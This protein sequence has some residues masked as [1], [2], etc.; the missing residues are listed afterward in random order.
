MRSE[1]E[2]PPL[3]GS[4]GGAGDGGGGGASGF[5]HTTLARAAATYARR[6]WLVLPCRPGSKEPLSA[7]VP[8]GLANAT[9][10]LATAISW[11]RRWPQ[12]NIAV[13]LGASHLAA[14]DIDNPA[15]AEAVLAACPGLPVITW[16]QKTPSGGLHVVVSYEEGE[17]PRTRHLHD[18]RGHRLG[19]LRSAGAYILVWPSQT[20]AGAYRLLSPHAPWEPGAVKSFLMADDAEAYLLGLLR[21]AG[22][23]LRETG[24]RPPAFAT[25]RPLQEGDGRN[26]ALYLTGRRLL[27]EGVPPQVVEETLRALNRNPDVIAQPLP[28][29][30]LDTVIGH[31]LTQPMAGNGHAPVSAL[32]GTLPVITLVPGAYD[33]AQVVDRAWEALLASGRP[34]RL[35]RQGDALVEVEGGGAKVI[36]VARLR[37]LLARAASWQRP[38]P[39]GFLPV[40]PPE[41]VAQAMLERPHPDLP[42]LRGVVRVPII[43]EEGI[44]ATPGYHATTGLYYLPGPGLEE[45]PP[46]PD[47]PTA[48]DVVEAK[49]L[50]LEELLGDF[51]FD[52]PASRAGAV[53]MLLTPFLHQLIAGPAPLFLLDKPA[54]GSGATLLA[55]AI[56][57]VATGEAPTY[58]PPRESEEEWRKAITSILMRGAGMV[59]IDNAR[60]LS[61]T[62]LS[63]AITATAWADRLLGRNSIITVPN[64]ATWAVSG[65]NPAL[66]LELA[67]RCV[68]VRLEPPSERPWTRTGFRYPNLLGWVKEHRAHLVWAALVLARHWLALGRPSPSCPRPGMFEAWAEVVGGVL[69]SAGIEG[70]LANVG[71]VYEEAEASPFLERARG[72]VA[73]WWQRFGEEAVTVAQLVEAAQE[74]ELEPAAQEKREKDRQARRLGTMLHRLRGRVFA[75][76]ATTV[77]VTKA[78]VDAHRKQGLWRLVPLGTPR[79]VREVAGS[80]KADAGHPPPVADGLSEFP[81]VPAT[82]RKGGGVS[83]QALRQAFEEEGGGD[84]L[85]EEEA[86]EA[87]AGAPLI[88]EESAPPPPEGPPHPPRPCPSCRDPDGWKGKGYRLCQ[89]PGVRVL[90]R[91]ITNPDH[92]LL[93]RPEEAVAVAQRLWQEADP[94]VL[95][96]AIERRGVCWAWRRELEP[97]LA[98]K[99]FMGF[100]PQVV[101]PLRA[102]IW[103]ATQ[104]RLEGG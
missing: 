29:R 51:P 33:L 73:M 52:C 87:G 86:A 39:H 59:L 49:R 101:L 25:G 93:H 71:E 30:E 80:P 63:S 12:A 37:E 83:E 19:E 41:A 95:V 36:G 70:F 79:E 43:T 1:G 34:P 26:A 65:N 66:S 76:E 102:F 42:P 23:E 16:C 40:P 11:W 50:L 28:E 75:L 6:G 104:P 3:Q 55:S 27:R 69:E 62:T 31:V 47:Q 78:G 10:D 74:E 67:R 100:E 53:A 9:D 60:A 85:A 58:L 92:Q 72:L 77:R 81:Q 38:S 94:D 56:A 90:L 18:A 48:E 82:S 84:L 17:P 98:V 64:L 21:E 35:F 5:Q 2:L 99:Q 57:L 45:I 24:P 96:L 88:R 44:I 32:A 61:S 46:V 15:L 91:T 7:A 4:G 13:N 89:A 97:V 54:P 20:G 103:G 8:R 14:L 22:V 68:R